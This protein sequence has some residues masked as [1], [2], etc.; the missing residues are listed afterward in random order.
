MR[1]NYVVNVTKFLFLLCQINAQMPS[2][3]SALYDHSHER[4]HS[5]DLNQYYDSLSTHLPKVMIIYTWIKHPFAKCSNVYE[6][7]SWRVTTLYE[8]LQLLVLRWFH[9][10]GNHQ[11]I[12]LF[13]ML[14]AFVA[15]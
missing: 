7:F 14:G 3:Y 5:F 12:Q 4:K 10:F 9:Y 2:I 8:K 11:Q 15:I 13:L 6:W 1:E